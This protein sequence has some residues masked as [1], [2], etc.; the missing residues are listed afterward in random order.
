[1]HKLIRPQKE[2]KALIAARTDQCPDW[3]HFP[4]NDKNQV[5]DELL[6]MQNFRCAYCERSIHKN[7][8]IEDGYDGHIEHFRRKNVNFFPEHTFDWENLFYSCSTGSTCGRYKDKYLKNREQYKLLINPC[9]ENPE[10]FFVF[11][12][13]G[14]IAV[15]DGLNDFQIKRA[16][17]TIKAFHL[18]EPSLTKLRK[19]IQKQYCS[20]IKQYPKEK[21]L[22]YLH[23]N[24]SNA[25][26]IT[27]IYNYFG[28]RIIS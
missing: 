12:D 17:F 19:D 18:D 14:R 24:I 13:R 1:M 28:E 16:E 23:D 9:L 10:D 6:R 25:Q 7:R 2:P 5:R 21:I 20:W 4:Q 26:F 8:E 3:D 27:A 22:E 11:D 15:R